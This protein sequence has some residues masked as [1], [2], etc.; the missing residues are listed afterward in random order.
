MRWIALGFC[1]A[2]ASVAAV[3]TAALAQPPQRSERPDRRAGGEQAVSADLI[4]L[5]DDLRLSDSQEAAWHD[6]TVAI[7]PNPETQARHQATSEL[8]P[9]VPTPRRIA[10]I[11]ATMA[12]DD[13]DFRRQ[14]AAV[15]AF[16]NKL[17]PEQQR[18]FDR[19]T[20]PAG[21]DPRPG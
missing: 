3:G 6:Y 5:H 14:G 1:L 11:E 9:M 2:A 17:S 4:R 10:L 15:N 20:L 12:Q 19:D 8:L 16:Y 18:V 13:L 7:A 21:S